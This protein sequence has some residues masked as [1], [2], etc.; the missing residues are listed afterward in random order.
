MTKKKQ[1]TV[2]CIPMARMKVIFTFLGSVLGTK[3]LNPDIVKDFIASRAA[4]LAIMK[5]EVAS[6][7]KLL[8]SW[9]EKMK[10]HSDKTEDEIKAELLSSPMTVFSRTKE[11]NPYI[12][13]YMIKGM[14]K[15]NSD[16]LRKTLALTKGHALNPQLKG[17]KNNMT[18][19]AHVFVNEDMTGKSVLLHDMDGNDIGNVQGELQRPL[20]VDTMQGPR[21]ALAISEN[22]PVTSQIEFNIFYMRPVTKEILIETLNLGLFNGIGQW[23]NSGEH[24]N[25]MFEILEEEENF[26]FDPVKVRESIIEALAS[27][28]NRPGAIY[29]GETTLDAA[30]RKRTAK[31]TTAAEKIA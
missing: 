23:R 19:Y 22:I 20:R 9:V 30:L 13:S 29:R 4:D 11:G 28:K 27:D 8:Q 5:A 24:G 26:P 3:P 1:T 21:V 12:N 10:K 17:I 16:N 15:E 31:A 18:K 2:S 14:L 25:F 7:H 6:A